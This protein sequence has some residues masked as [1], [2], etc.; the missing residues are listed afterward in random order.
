MAAKPHG[1]GRFGNEAPRPF[2]PEREGLARG[3]KTLRRNARRP[4]GLSREPGFTLPEPTGVDDPGGSALREPGRRNPGQ[5]SR[6]EVLLEALQTP[7]TQQVNLVQ[8][9]C[10]QA[11][12]GGPPRHPVDPRSTEPGPSHRLRSGLRID[13]ER[14]TNHA[15]NGGLVGCS[16]R[17]VRGHS[18]RP[19]LGR[20]SGGRIN[21]RACPVCLIDTTV[22]ALK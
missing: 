8:G 16:G 14:A 10:L 3:A 15:G 1:L 2:V 4:V 19:G 21:G 6:G 13:F 20:S 18:S 17:V 12:R 7:L 22:M 5:A 11:P 9:E